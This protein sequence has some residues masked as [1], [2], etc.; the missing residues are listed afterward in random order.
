MMDLL[1]VSNALTGKMEGMTAITSSM[2]NN[3][4]C[5]RLAQCNGSI[6]QH[7]Y[8]KTAMSY[9]KNVQQCYEKNGKILSENII[10]KNQLPF[11]NSQYCRFESHGDLH[12]ETHLENFINIAKKNPHCQFAL[13]TKQYKIIL[14]YFKTHKQPKNLNIVISSLMVNKPINPTPF[15][16]IGLKVKIFTVWDKE[17][18]KNVNINCGGKKCIDCLN[19]YKKSGKIK[20]INEI[21]K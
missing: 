8:S 1:K 2:T 17:A 9:R 10:P 15:E 4:N 3:V 7:C 12:N 13:W 16:A 18:A 20:V 11:V 5:Q 6:C 19:C 14:D 21:I